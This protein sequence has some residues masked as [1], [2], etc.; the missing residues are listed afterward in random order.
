[1]SSEI[2]FN[3]KLVIN[4]GFKEEHTVNN[5][6]NQ[7]TAGAVLLKQSI[8]TSDTV[9][10]L[11]GVTA[12]R[13]CSIKNVDATNYIDIGPTAAGAIVKMFRLQPGEQLAGP[14]VPSCVLRAIAHTGAVILEMLFAET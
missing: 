11:T 9:I 2:T 7:T 3:T 8:P 12:A 5:T 6:I 14:L 10:T 1:M 13:L 4:N